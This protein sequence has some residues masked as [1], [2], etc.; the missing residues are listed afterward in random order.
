MSRRRDT[1]ARPGERVSPGQVRSWSW[2]MLSACLSASR[3]AARLIRPRAAGTIRTREAVG[4]LAVMVVLTALLSW[5]TVS[6]AGRAITRQEAAAKNAA[7]SLV[8]PAPKAAAG[9]PRRF[10]AVSEPGAA[11][12]IT[13]LRH[14]FGAVGAALIANARREAHAG[15]SGEPPSSVTATWTSGLYGQ[16]G[17]ID[18][19]TYHP[20]WVMYLGLDASGTLG[21]RTDVIG[22]L[23]LGIHGPYARAR[24]WPVAA[25][26]RGGTA[27][28]TIARLART[29]VAV[30]GWATGHTIGALASPA[31]DTSVAELATLMAKM[32]FDLQHR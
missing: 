5:V 3:R 1:A 26:H 28:C 15:A 29:R 10:G 18:P 13:V 7:G 24:P 14:R 6:I 4:L 22:R 23:L 20:A 25:G 12:I 2:R 11:P 27:S 8:I 16:P 32:R 17:H 21:L 9:L 31:R 30:C 19:V